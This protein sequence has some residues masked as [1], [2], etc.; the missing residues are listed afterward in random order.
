MPRSGLKIVTRLAWLFAFSVC[1]A[2]QNGGQDES[3]CYSWRAGRSVDPRLIFLRVCAR[4]ARAALQVRCTRARGSISASGLSPVWS[5]LALGTRASQPLW[6]MGAGALR[7]QLGQSFRHHVDGTTTS[8]ASVVRT[9]SGPAKPASN[10]S[11]DHT[12]LLTFARAI[13]CV[14]VPLDDAELFRDFPWLGAIA[15]PPLR[16]SP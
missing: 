1:D 13:F 10:V 6:S 16:Q 8:A 15:L 9:S 11:V 2:P 12:G 7:A 5:R 3:A 14:P 4:R